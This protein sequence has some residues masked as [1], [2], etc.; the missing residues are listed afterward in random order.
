MGNEKGE[1][2]VE[3]NGDGKEERRQRKGSGE[4]G[5]KRQRGWDGNRKEE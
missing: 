5:R 4:R 2:K 1:G 3:E